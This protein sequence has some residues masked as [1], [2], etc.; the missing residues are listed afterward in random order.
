MKILKADQVRELDAYTIA[1]EPISSLDLMERASLAFVR[2]FCDR[3]VNTRP[4]VVF[5]GKGNNGGDGLA[6]SRLLSEK[7]FDVKVYIVEYSEDASAEFRQNFALLQNHVAPAA[8]FTNADIPQINPDAICIDALLGTGLSRPVSGLLADVITVLN[9]VPNKVVSVDIA[10]GLYTDKAN[11]E[12]DVIIEP[13][14]TITFQLPKLAFM[15]PK[16]GRFT[17][18][19]HNVQ[20]GLH[21]ELLT[22]LPTSYYFTDQVA[23]NKLIRPR[24]KF[25]HKGTFGHA[26]LLSGSYGKMGAAVLSSRAC[27][28]SGVGLLTIHIPQCGY[29][30]AQ[31]SVPEAMVSV[32]R[33]AKNI[34]ELPDVASYSAIGIGPGIGKEPLTARVLENLLTSIKVPMVID[35]DA[36]NLLS[37]NTALLQKLPPNTVLTPHPKEFE[38][39]A[40]KSKNEFERLELGKAFARDHQAIICLKGA[41]T[42][43]I[44]PDGDVH[45]NSTGNPGMATG[46]TGDVLTGVILSLLAQGY[47]AHEAAILGVYQHGLAGDRAALKYG[48]SALI[49]SDVVDSLKW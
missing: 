44:L 21:E 45:F 17:G 4:V 33:E 49:A 1:N 29:D 11:D 31:I 27:L 40:G 42:A 41:N 2:C 26:L 25:S 5:C 8:I 23:A 22:R 9:Q 7:S 12:D 48:Q 39:L 36:L 3:F 15:M 20:I 19:W 46:G 34:S 10:S 32:D 24:G 28:R 43:V 37:E 35:A 47:P 13:D 6:I 38:R 30:I 18:E 14:C 16:N